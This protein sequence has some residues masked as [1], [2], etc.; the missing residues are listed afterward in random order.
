MY[1]HHVIKSGSNSLLRKFYEAQ[2]NQPVKG[3]WVNLLE[4]DK[5]E[6]NIYKNDDEI[7]KM[8]KYKFKKMI[9]NQANELALK[10]LNNLKL[11]HSKM[12]N[13]K[14]SVGKLNPSSYLSDKRINPDQAKFIFKVRTRMLSM[15]CNFKNQFKENYTCDLCN[16]DL[17]NQEHLLKCKVLQH[18]I[19]E[20]LNSKIN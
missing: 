6:F 11:K 17:D 8:S 5:E 9:K 19:P 10:Y 18:F 1:W 20:I 12:T 14:I 15:K 3:D 16:E 13:I 2:K 4:K 7:R